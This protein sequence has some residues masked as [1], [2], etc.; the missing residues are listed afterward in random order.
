MSGHP[1]PSEAWTGA[2]ADAVNGNPKY[3]EAGKAWTHGSVAMVIAADPDR[4]LNVEKG[5]ILDVNEG[6]CRGTE[7]VTGR[8]AASVADFVIVATYDDWRSVIGGEIDPIKGM[9][10]GRLKLT[11]GHLPTM[12]RFVESSRQLVVSASLVPTDF[13]RMEP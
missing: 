11:K 12:L 7:Y 13:S 9:M 5:M 2:Y 1:F 6:Q 10:Q 4:G 8:E 3:R